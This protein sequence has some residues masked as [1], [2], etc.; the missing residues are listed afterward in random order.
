VK[1]LK[2]LINAKEKDDSRTNLMFSGKKMEDFRKIS[3]YGITQHNTVYR[4]ISL[5]GGA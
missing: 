2:E 4:V 5:R 1:E 3:D